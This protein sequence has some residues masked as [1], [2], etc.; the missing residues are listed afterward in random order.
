[1][2]QK[3]AHN[4][5]LFDALV[6][7]IRADEPG[8][9]IGVMFG[10]P[11]AFVGRRMAF[12]VYGEGIGAK[13]PQA[14]AARLIASGQAT[15]FRPFDRPAMKEWVELRVKPGEALKIVPILAA[16]VRY[17]RASE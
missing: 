10:C 14:E 8:I 15:A 12:C 2:H 6:M 16:A 4:R 3:P 13:L 7:Q 1:M 5:A 17:A 9:R 11:A